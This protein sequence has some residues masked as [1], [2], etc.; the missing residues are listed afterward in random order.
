MI[1]NDSE[2][3]EAV[4]GEDE[5][6]KRRGRP[7]GSKNKPKTTTSPWR[8]R[9]K[10]PKPTETAVLS[11]IVAGPREDPDEPDYSFLDDEPEHIDR[12]NEPA[13]VGSWTWTGTGIKVVVNFRVA[14]SSPSID[15]EEIAWPP[16]WPIPQLNDILRVSK[17]KAGRVQFVEY[18]FG[19]GAI[20]ISVT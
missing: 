6:P 7:K 10:S 9:A 5:K 8:L 11:S 17:T 14:L 16:N 1:E 19:N 13:A 12:T 2:T 20:I 18:D 15:S 4:P 3:F